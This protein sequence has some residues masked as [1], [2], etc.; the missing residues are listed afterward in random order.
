MAQQ[1][2]IYD[3]LKQDH[4]K[5]RDILKKMVDSGSGAI[6]TR[7]QLVEKLRREL[8]AHS[9]AEEHVL[10][11]ELEQHKESMELAVDGE[12]EHHLVEHLLDE[13][14]QT[15]P[16]NPHWIAKAKLIQS[17]IE[18]HVSEEEEQMFPQAQQ[19]LNERQAEELGERFKQEKQQEQQRM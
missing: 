5:V 8:L 6:K 10:Y 11:Q 13:L 2:P 9:H 18:H 12:E 16:D 17:L 14:Q 4:D 19:V 15:E 7:Q 3:Q 1:A